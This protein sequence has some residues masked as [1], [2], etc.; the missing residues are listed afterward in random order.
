[1]FKKLKAKIADVKARASWR[2]TPDDVKDSIQQIIDTAVFFE[3][4]ARDKP[5]WT[6][7]DLVNAYW[8]E[9]LPEAQGL[10]ESPLREGY[11]EEDSGWRR[12]SPALYDGIQD[13]QWLRED[14]VRASRYYS[15]RDPLYHHATWFVIW[16]AFGGQVNIEAADPDVQAIIDEFNANPDNDLLARPSGRWELAQT[17]IEDGEIF[18][19]YF[20]D[21]VY[22]D[23]RT[24]YVLTDEIEQVVFDDD[25]RRK[26]TYYKR[27]CAKQSF[28]FTAGAYTTSGV[29]TDYWPDTSA[30]EAQFSGDRSLHLRTHTG[31]EHATVGDDFT[32]CYMRQYKINSRS[33]RGMPAH[34]SGIPGA[35]AYKGFLQDRIVLLIAL[36]TFAFQQNVSGNQT[37]IDRLAT[38]WGDTVLDRWNADSDARRT[39]QERAP[40]A[41]VF[42]GNDQARLE[43]FRTDSGASN[44]YLDGRMIRQLLAAAAGMTEQDLTGDPQIGNL[45]TAAAMAGPQ[46]KMLSWWQELFRGIFEDTY[47]FAIEQKLI[48]GELLPLCEDGTKRDLTFT[49]NMPD[50]VTVDETAQPAPRTQQ[51]PGAE[52]DGT[53]I[54]PD[55][56]AD[57]LSQMKETL[58]GMR[59][60]L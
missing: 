38:Q 12:L 42:I 2:L 51:E 45:A 36:A 11:L 17:L 10:T 30:E 16:Y 58:E 13:M 5:D 3:S 18:M 34:Y 48:R 27:V 6:P 50:L 25:N 15:M 54:L 59:G 20:V 14:A 8:R 52:D 53:P 39:D 22:G 43:Q 26:P 1:M 21:A 55:N 60:G 9:R 7:Q 40:G 35:K 28:D 41:R 32:R 31:T 47:N 4:V 44:A 29:Q 37:A 49:V 57:M 33:M 46:L 23:V 24:S 19:T 56:A